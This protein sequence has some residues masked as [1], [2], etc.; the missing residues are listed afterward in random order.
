VNDESV[1]KE[2]TMGSKKRMSVGMGF[3]AGALVGA[4]AVFVPFASAGHPR[5]D[6]RQGAQPRRSVRKPAAPPAVPKKDAARDS[7]EASSDAACDVQL[8]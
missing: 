8:D 2:D 5:T 1:A 6:A 7:S 4:I 3:A